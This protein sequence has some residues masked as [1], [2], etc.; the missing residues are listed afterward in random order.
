MGTLKLGNLD[1]P[2][3]KA[4]RQLQGVLSAVVL[5]VRGRSGSWSGDSRS[6]G[7]CDDRPPA[8]TAIGSGFVILGSVP[9]EVVK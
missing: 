4:R 7:S 3:V 1:N 8:R 6:F 2:S 9:G 5:M